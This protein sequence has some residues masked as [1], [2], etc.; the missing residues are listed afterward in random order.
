VNAERWLARLSFSFFI[1][2][3]V[4]FWEMYKISQ[5][6]RGPVPTWRIGVYVVGCLLA[7]VLGALGVRARHR[8]E[9]K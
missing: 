3:A 7:I 2:A 1:I 4:L 5:G 6:E 9:I 8:Q